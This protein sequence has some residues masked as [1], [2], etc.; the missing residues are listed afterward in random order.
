MVLEIMDETDHI[1]SHHRRYFPTG[2]FRRG[3]LT[4]LILI[5]LLGTS[6]H[7]ATAFGSFGAA[8]RSSLLERRSLALRSSSAAFVAPHEDTL[9]LEGLARLLDDLEAKLAR[10]A[11]E[12]SAVKRREKLLR[13][14]FSDLPLNRAVVGPST[15]GPRA[16]RGVF[17][18]RDIAAGE[19][20]TL[21]PCDAL[22]IARTSS[23]SSVLFGSAIPAADRDPSSCFLSAPTAFDYQL[24]VPCSASYSI[25][26]DPGRCADPRY[27]GHMINDA[28]GGEEGEG[29]GTFESNAESMMIECV[30]EGQGSARGGGGGGGGGG[31]E[32]NDR[33]GAVEDEEMLLRGIAYGVVATRDITAGEE[34]FMRYGRKYWTSR[35]DDGDGSGV[36]EEE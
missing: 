7:P 6:F 1:T 30:E 26:G 10:E 8:T 3:A 12:L 17:A 23:P 32:S 20:V 31:G 29:S 21:Y 27:I 18:T 14:R 22:I 24:R 33:E 13:Q 19:L 15:I 28:E 25:V 9:T 4:A 35:G 2:A 5:L 34:V 16:G 11:P 36:R